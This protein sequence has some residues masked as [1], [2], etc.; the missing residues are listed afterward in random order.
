MAKL[1]FNRALQLMLA[2]FS[3]GLVSVLYSNRVVALI[4]SV[5]EVDSLAPLDDAWRELLRILG[6][7]VRDLDADKLSEE[8]FNSFRA[9]L[10]IG[11]EATRERRSIVMSTNPATWIASAAP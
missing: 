4:T 1:D 3:L 6:E 10:Q 7:A 11:M 9:I 2:A 8:S 5:Q